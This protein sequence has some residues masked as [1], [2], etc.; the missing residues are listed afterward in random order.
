M[1]KLRNLKIG[2]VDESKYMYLGMKDAHLIFRNKEYK[3]G[4][5]GYNLFLVFKKVNILY[6]S[7]SY[8]LR[9]RF[10]YDGKIHEVK[11]SIYKIKF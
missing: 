1:K 6:E 3:L 11:E 9:H 5:L 7:K 8:V 4:F 10:G 2:V